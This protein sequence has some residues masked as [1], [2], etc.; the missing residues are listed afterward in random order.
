MAAH[1][2]LSASG[3]SKWMNCAG[4]ILAESGMPEDEGSDFAREGT[5]AHELA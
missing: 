1:A 3:S 4:S 2:I 5:A